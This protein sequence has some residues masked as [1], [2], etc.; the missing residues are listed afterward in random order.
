MFGITTMAIS[1]EPYA[2]FLWG[3][4][5]DSSGIEAYNEN[6]NWVFIFIFFELRLILLDRITLA[7]NKILTAL[8]KWQ[9]FPEF[10]EYSPSHIILIMNWYHTSPPD[11]N[12]NAHNVKF[13]R[14]W[15]STTGSKTHETQTHRNPKHKHIINTVSM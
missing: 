8:E 2:Q 3:F 15:C 4:H 9:F 12:E 13:N 10:F 7:F 5:W 6:E 14:A 11:Y 1:L